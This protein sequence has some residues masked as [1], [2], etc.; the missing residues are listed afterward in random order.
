MSRHHLNE[1]LRMYSPWGQKLNG[2]VIHYKRSA[3]QISSDHQLYF[4]N[5]K[6]VGK[7]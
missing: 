2:D 6:Y 7:S 4:R 5:M 3:S 1:T